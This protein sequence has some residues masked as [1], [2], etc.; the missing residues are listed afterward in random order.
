ME[1]SFCIFIITH[2][3]PENIITLKMLQQ[4][5]SKLPCYLVIDNED[6]KAEKYF[7]KYKENVLQFD[8]KYYASL[9]DNF[10]NSGNYR[11][12]THARNACFDFA[13]KLGFKYFLVL[14]DDYGQIKFRIKQGLVH[15]TGKYKII[16]NIDNV[17]LATLKYYLN[18]GFASICFSQGG[19]WF[20]G[21]TNFNKK[22]KRKAMNSF[23]CSTERRFNFI[24]RLNED[25]NTYMQ[26]SHTG[27]VFMTIPFIQVDQLPTQQNTGGMSTAYL[28]SGT[29]TKSFYTVICRPDCMR[30][31][32]M[33]TANT[34]FHHLTDWKA[35][36]P[37]IISEKYKK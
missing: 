4:A 21:E 17:F 20:G 37:C 5:G 22:P 24:S 14:D 15:P 1:N 16:K 29:Y 35:A 13:K 10:D 11:T 32:R 31:N 23:F 18:T 27:K 6:N 7:N 34:R 30:I 8:K 33:G 26:L 19:D 12:T 28:D 2:G 25:V 36:A 9:V 3:R